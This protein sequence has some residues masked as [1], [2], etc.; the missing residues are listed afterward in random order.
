MHER[1]SVTSA[2]FGPDYQAQTRTASAYAILVLL[3]TGS[4]V[5]SVPKIE[6]SRPGYEPTLT[7]QRSYAGV[8][9]PM[10]GLRLPK[11]AACACRLCADVSGRPSAAASSSERHA[12]EH[13]APYASTRA[14]WA[15]CHCPGGGGA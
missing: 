14:G 6:L 13:R 8:V 4:A 15:Y 11:Q 9:S 10:H 1:C 12:V 7:L 5:Q 3:C 2:L